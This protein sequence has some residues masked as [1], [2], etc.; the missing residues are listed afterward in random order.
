MK[1]LAL[2]LLGCHLAVSYGIQGSVPLFLE[3]GKLDPIADRSSRNVAVSYPT[4]LS[5]MTLV[6][7][8]SRCL[9][10]ASLRAFRSSRT[11]SGSPC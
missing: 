2:L 8:R 3:N 11:V 7:D 6:W 9:P 10:V 5:H 1:G 4:L